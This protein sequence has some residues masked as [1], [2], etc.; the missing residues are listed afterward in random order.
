MDS[1][2]DFWTQLLDDT[3]GV[4]IDTRKDILGWGDKEFNGPI[5]KCKQKLLKSM[6]FSLQN[7]IQVFVTDPE[8]CDNRFIFQPLFKNSNLKHQRNNRLTVF[9]QDYFGLPNKVKLSV[10]QLYRLNKFISFNDFS[11]LFSEMYN[12]TPTENTYLTIKHHLGNIYGNSPKHK[13]PP[14]SS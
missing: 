5:H 3:L 10:N 9:Q 13:Y 8:S 7:L 2:D 4:T 6:L 11:K 1:Y 12:L 14:P